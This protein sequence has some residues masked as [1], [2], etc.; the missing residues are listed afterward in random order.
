MEVSEDLLADIPAWMGFNMEE[1]LQSTLDVLQA[2]SDD[3]ESRLEH[4]SESHNPSLQAATFTCAR[5]P[6]Y[7]DPTVFCSG[8]V[9][10]DFYLPNTATVRQ[11]E[12]NVRTWSTLYS[13][14]LNTTCLGDL[15]R[16]ICSSTYLP[17]SPGVVPG[18]TSTYEPMKLDNG[19]TV[20]MPYRRPCRSICTAVTSLSGTC[21]G[22]LQTLG[23]TPNCLRLDAY[24]GYSMFDAVSSALSA[25]PADTHGG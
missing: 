21:K 20:P 3:Y 10:Y 7:R 24:S 8:I 16:M 18:N 13:S 4:H 9:N 14:F 17:C 1:E 15:K 5:L 2:E 22:R 23:V 11:F 6:A 12:T 19:A 25:V